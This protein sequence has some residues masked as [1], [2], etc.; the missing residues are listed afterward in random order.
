[1][2]KRKLSEWRKRRGYS[3]QDLAQK[4]GVSIK[5][6]SNYE[7][8][9]FESAKFETVVNI[10]KELDIELDQLEIKESE[11]PKQKSI[12]RKYKNERYI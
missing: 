9:G 2:N 1:M 5:S 10:L 12:E 4:V 8:V 6:I 3:Q 7:N 11:K